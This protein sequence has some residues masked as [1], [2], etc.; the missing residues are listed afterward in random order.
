MAS[1]L[2]LLFQLRADNAQAK[3]VLADTRAAVTQLRGQF[4]KDLT[5]MQGIAKAALAD[6]GENV[7]AFVGQRLPLVGGAFLRVTSHL[8]G[9]NEELKKGGPQT[10]ALADQIDGIAK[11]SGK[12]STE[13]ARFLTTF[14]RLEG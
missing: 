10:R 7:N 13:V 12:S 8:K 3:S 14:T 9:L 6:I 5:G 11:S 2:S 4:G 1:D